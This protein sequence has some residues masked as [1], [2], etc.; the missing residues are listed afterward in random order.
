MKNYTIKVGELRRI[1]TERENKGD[2]KPVMFG[3]DESKKI[4]DKAYSDMKKETEKY[5][6]QSLEPKKQESKAVEDDNKGMQ[7]LLYNAVSK[8]YSDKVKSQM[9]GY[10][11]AE[12][13]K[14]SKNA[15]FGNAD[16]Q[17]DKVVKDA[18]KKAKDG[19]KKKDT[20]S[21]IGL[22]GREL[23]KDE[24]ENQRKTVYESKKIKQLSFKNTRFL[25]EEHVMSIV[26]DE[27][28][29]EGKKFIMKDSMSN[30][31]L[32]EWHDE[33]PK[34]TKKINLQLVN[35]QKERMKALWNYKSSD[36]FQGTNSKTRVDE[37]TKFGDL[38]NKARK[39][40]K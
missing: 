23:P 4:N 33:C 19:K 31:Y 3:S 20:A 17:D 21:E 2:F 29:K 38:V 11:S 30:E 15:E 27:Y 12:N 37:E 28:K 6:G 39:L 35:E 22:A 24:I 1:I 34:L 26:P 18:E 8:V 7:D 40:M 25:N 16:F 36:A 9:K 32:V 14:N 13:E 5:N 10:T